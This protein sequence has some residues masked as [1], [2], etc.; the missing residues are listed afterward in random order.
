MALSYSIAL[1]VGKHFNDNRFGACI[2]PVH[3][4]AHCQG[5]AVGEIRDGFDIPCGRGLEGAEVAM[6]STLALMFIAAI[7]ISTSLG[8][9]YKAVRTQENKLSRY[10]VFTTNM[11]QHQDQSRSR[12][13]RDDVQQQGGGWK[14][15]KTSLTVMASSLKMSIVPSR[16]NSAPDPAMHHTRMRSNDTQSQSRAVMHKAFGYSFAWLLSY[17]IFIIASVIKIMNGNSNLVLVYVTTAFTALQGCFNLIIYMYP[18]IISVK[19]K[20]SKQRGG[21]EMRVSWCDAI[22]IVFWSRGNDAKRKGKGPARRHRSTF[23]S[24]GNSRPLRTTT[25]TRMN[26]NEMNGNESYIYMKSPQYQYQNQCIG[27]RIENK[28]H[29]THHGDHKEAKC[30]E[31]KGEEVQFPIHTHDRNRDEDVNSDVMNV[32]DDGDGEDRNDVVGDTCTCST[33]EDVPT[34]SCS[35]SHLDDGDTTHIA[36]AINKDHMETEASCTP[37]PVCHSTSANSRVEDEEDRANQD[38]TNDVLGGID[39]IK[40]EE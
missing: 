21:E 8:M 27:E 28:K 19:K 40:D 23:T 14:R 20:K 15:M 13:Q 34:Y 32:R 36:T 6:L 29:Q 18:K 4:P 16:R 7:V 10:S 31:E 38:G 2:S 24:R 39:S 26:S 22:V 33:S 9:I 17:G 12:A 25:T 5:Y 11:R 37:I 35:Y 30:E 1:L 3:Y